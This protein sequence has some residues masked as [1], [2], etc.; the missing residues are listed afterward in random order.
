M[1][2]IAFLISLFIT[3]LG[4]QG[5][6][7]PLKLL[8]FARKFESQKGLYAAAALRLIMGSSLFYSAITSRIPKVL[9]AFGITTFVSGLVTPFFGVQRFGRILTWWSAQGHT[10]MRAWAI[11]ALGV[12]L[13]LAWAVIPWQ[14]N[15]PGKE[16]SQNEEI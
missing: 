12:G 7:S 9:R 15:E 14:G 3:A 2:S 6:I 10:F 13:L 5:I 8:S 1:K 16:H 4:A 11:L